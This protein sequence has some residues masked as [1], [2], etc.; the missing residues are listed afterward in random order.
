MF[1]HQVG[2]WPET[3]LPAFPTRVLI[4]LLP[5]T[6]LIVFWYLRDSVLTVR[7]YVWFLWN[8]AWNMMVLF[9]ALLTLEYRAMEGEVP[10]WIA[11]FAYAVIFLGV[12]MTL[13]NLLMLL[14]VWRSGGNT[15]SSP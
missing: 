4:A 9:A 6:V 10:M 2:E 15:R 13:L 3:L 7:R 11:D 5:A 8:L 1:E 12:P 14:I